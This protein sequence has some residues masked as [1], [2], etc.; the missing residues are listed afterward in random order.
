MQIY[1]YI[2]SYRIRKLGRRIWQYIIIYNF[3]TYVNILLTLAIRKDINLYERFTFDMY[4]RK[5]LFSVTYRI[6][7]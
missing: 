1:I 7:K 4:R 3:L 2:N 6:K 5:I